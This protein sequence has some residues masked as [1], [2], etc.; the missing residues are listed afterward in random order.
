MLVCLCSIQHEQIC[1]LRFAPVALTAVSA[2]S[3]VAYTASD[4][5]LC[6]GK[7]RNK[8]FKWHST[9]SSVGC[10]WQAV[11][12]CSK[13]LL[14][15]QFF[16]P[17]MSS[18]RVQ[19]QGPTWP[20][21]F[22]ITTSCLLFQYRSTSCNISQRNGCRLLFTR[23]IFLHTETIT[24]NCWEIGLHSIIITE[25]RWKKWTEGCIHS[26]YIGNMWLYQFGLFTLLEA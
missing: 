21:C 8:Q 26:A 11:R 1:I 22:S 17:V 20:W 12:L 2:E 16:L 25:G 19:Q 18:Q 23:V 7:K 10:I 15:Y 14:S 3:Q 4:G 24:N 5:V 6:L 9:A 13:I